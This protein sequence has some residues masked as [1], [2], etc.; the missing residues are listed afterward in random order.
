MK[1]LSK[2]L[3]VLFVAVSSSA[4]SQTF[5]FGH[6]NTQELVALMPE[7][8]SASA[9]LEKYSA[10]LNETMEAM[11]VE[12]NTKLN[13]YQ[14]KQATWTAVVLEAKQ[15]ELQE[16][17]ARYEQFQ[18]S[19][20]QEYQQMQSL[21]LAPVFKKA[22]DAIQKIGKEQGFIYIFDTSTGAIP[23]INA[24]QS[25]DLT[26]VAKKELRIPADKKLPV[27]KPQ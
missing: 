13:T 7:R 11:Q 26:S 24:D 20:S 1:H 4:F 14:Q 18:Q 23:F 12:F 6:L 3:L 21:L 9:K 8:D 17:Q 25:I 22:N 27:Q 16:I 19:A 10:D 2:I 15:K 5:K